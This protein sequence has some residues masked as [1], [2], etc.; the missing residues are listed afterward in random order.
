[1]TDAL[2]MN[3]FIAELARLPDQL[4]ALLAGRLEDELR[5]RPGDGE[6]SVKEIACHLR[7]AARIY[8]ERVFLTA[9]HERPTLAAYD[10]AALARDR[11]YQESD[12][13]AIVPEL[14]SWREET[15]HLLAELPREAWDRRAVHEETGEMTLVHLVAHMIEHEADHLRG[16]A[17]LLGTFG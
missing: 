16:I 12:T 9:T 5:S 17:R 1:M 7:D 11:N 6:W 14:R 2:A 10:E 8:H 13:S 15:V 4:E 3:P